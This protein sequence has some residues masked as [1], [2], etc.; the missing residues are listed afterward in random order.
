M[1]T[2]AGVGELVLDGQCLRLKNRPTKS[3]WPTIIWPAG[4]TPHVHQGVVQIRNGGGRIL[5]EV[6]NEIAGGGGYFDR[7]SGECSGPIWRAN[8]IKTLPDVEIYFPKQDGTLAA[9]QE[10]E[11][12]VGKLV[13]YGKCLIVDNAIRTNDRSYVGISLLI[14]WPNT[15]V[16]RM[17]DGQVGIADATGNVVALV[18][19]EVQ[20]SAFDISYGQAM[21]K[22]GLAAIS[23]ACSGPYWVV[24]EDFAGA[25][26][27]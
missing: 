4:F 17:E 11:L 9:D 27:P 1:L 2:A 19:D 26:A 16:L 23:P 20:F 24:G 13:L 10:P 5:A 7:G 6:G 8:K 21:A 15:F 22:G 25:L 3:H 14:I 12:L 18:G